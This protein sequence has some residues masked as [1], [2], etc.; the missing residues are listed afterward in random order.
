MLSYTKSW[1]PLT[2]Q[3]FSCAFVSQEDCISSSGSFVLGAFSP[4]AFKKIRPGF[5]SLEF[6]EFQV[7]FA[8]ENLVQFRNSTFSPIEFSLGYAA[9]LLQDF[10]GHHS[11]GFLNPE[12]DHPLE[13][14][15]DAY[16]W[17]SRPSGFE[18]HKPD[19]LAVNFYSNVSLAYG[20]Y[21]GNESEVLSTV[22]VSQSWNSFEALMAAEVLAIGLD[23]TYKDDILK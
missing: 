2:H 8:K 9:H 11:N 14:A 22:Q 20:K 19:Q 6:A 12:E 21:V 1:G 3:L 18:I 16:L 17:K 7:E 13:L 10:C 15:V 5:H 23:F 4:D